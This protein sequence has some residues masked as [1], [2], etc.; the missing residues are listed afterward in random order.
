MGKHLPLRHPCQ[1]PIGI[2]CMLWSKQYTDS[3]TKYFV[4]F[5][6]VCKENIVFCIQNNNHKHNNKVSNKY[7][8]NLNFLR[9]LDRIIIHVCF[10]MK[11]IK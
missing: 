3:S 2:K 6:H 7:N 4:H 5:S 1:Q 9:P 10:Q 11:S 8:E